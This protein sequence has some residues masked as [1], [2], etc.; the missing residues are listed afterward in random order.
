MK[1]LFGFL[2]GLVLVFFVVGSAI[3]FTD[4][5]IL[6]KTIGEGPIGTLIW[7]D[8]FTYSHATPDDFEVPWDVVNSATLEISGYWIDA[9]DNEV[10]ISGTKVGTLNTGG[11]Y[12]EHWSWSQWKMI[13][14]DDPSLS[15]FDIGSVFSTWTN[16][17]SLDVSIETNGDFFDGWLELSS[18]TFI[19]D[20]ENA[21]APVPEPATMV[22][23]GLGL[24]GL[25]GVS[26]KKYRK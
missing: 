25:A 19:L 21:T 13:G 18:S 16:G 20:Y 15:V 17:A 24:V 8:T 6:N 4:T 5:Q 1:K 11:E 3:A 22:L 7:G 9:E 14:F 12:G 23:F 2:M 10:E 26:R